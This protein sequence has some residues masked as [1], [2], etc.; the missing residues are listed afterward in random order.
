MKTKSENEPRE[1]FVYTAAELL[2]WDGKGAAETA[3]R[4]ARTERG[5]VP[6][7]NR[8]PR[9][10][11]W[12]AS[13]RHLK[14]RP[15]MRRY[16]TTDA[17]IYPLLKQGE[18]DGQTA[19]TLTDDGLTICYCGGAL[20]KQMRRIYMEGYWGE[21]RPTAVPIFQ[22]GRPNGPFPYHGDIDRY[23]DRKWAELPE[24]QRQRILTGRISGET[25]SDFFSPPRTSAEQ[26]YVLLEHCGYSIAEPAR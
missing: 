3:I 15:R 18:W 20:L 12:A 4:Q 2:A 7:G 16:L 10:P 1:P 11:R 22:G 6:V 19:V 26:V 8:S 14:E 17:C 9:W 24:P 25:V 23:L 5:A 13:A 21:P